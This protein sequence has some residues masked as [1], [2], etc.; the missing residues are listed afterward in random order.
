LKTIGILLL[1]VL[2]ML[3]GCGGE[4][5]DDAANGTPTAE[6]LESSAVVTSSPQAAPAS[7]DEFTLQ[8]TGSLTG[9]YTEAEGIGTYGTI[10]GRTQIQFTTDLGAPGTVM[11]ELIGEPATGTYQ[12]IPSSQTLGDGQASGTF[13]G[14]PQT[15]YDVTGTLTLEA[16]PLGLS[17]SFELTATPRNAPGVEPVIVTC[18]FAI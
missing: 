7:G 1:G 14:D 16:R 18:T 5:G 2:F 10:S 12:V 13:F 11:L 8:Y 15:A 6:G 17:G 9:G 4:G 3:A